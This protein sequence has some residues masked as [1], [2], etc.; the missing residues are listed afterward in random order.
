[1]LDTKPASPAAVSAYG[2]AYLKEPESSDSTVSAVLM[3]L[4]AVG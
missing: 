2:G 3:I 1:M 4:K